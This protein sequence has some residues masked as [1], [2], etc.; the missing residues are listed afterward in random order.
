LR[1]YYDLIVDN[2]ILPVFRIHVDSNG[3]AISEEHKYLQNILENFKKIVDI[4]EFDYVPLIGSIWD[5]KEF[6]KDNGSDSVTEY[7]N[8]RIRFAFIDKDNKFLGFLH[9]NKDVTIGAMMIAAFS[10]N[11]VVAV[12]RIEND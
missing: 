2:D 11:P 3:V 4:S 12:N 6:S 9:Y 10:S 8:N 1:K 7:L 5:G